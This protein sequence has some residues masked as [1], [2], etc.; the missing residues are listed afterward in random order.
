[1][2]NQS[3]LGEDTPDR[4]RDTVLFLLGI[5]LMLR[6]VEEHYYLRRTT[7]QTQSQLSFVMSEWASLFLTQF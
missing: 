4:L 1:M 6:A 3:V 2:W 5:N 7:S